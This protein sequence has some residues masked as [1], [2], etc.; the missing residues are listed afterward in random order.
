MH[1]TDLATELLLQICH[2]LPTIQSVLALSSTCRH[3]RTL[4]STHRLPILYLA[5]EAELGPLPDA[6]RLVTH[7]ATQPVHIIRPAP[8]HSLALLE[9]LLAVG[10]VANKLVTLYPSQKWHGG[11]K[12]CFRRSLTSLEERHLRRAVYRL[13]LYKFAFHNPT[14]TRRTRL[15]PP[16]VRSRAALL[17]PWPASE[18]AEVLDIHTLLRGLLQY[19]ICPS[20]GTVLRRHKARYPL[21]QTPLVY[22]A[23]VKYNSSLQQQL[24]FQAKFFHSTPQVS[25]LLVS[26]RE[27]SRGGCNGMVEGWGDEIAHYYVVEDMLKL[28]PGQ[29]IWLFEHVTGTGGGGLVS[30]SAKDTVQSFVAGIGGEWFENNGET[31]G[32]TVAFVVGERGGEMEELRE[33]VE[34][35]VEGIVRGA[36]A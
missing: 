15:Q 29:I 31:F 12:S 9:R 27:Y 4:I 34:D 13:W 6:I 14:H 1:L 7:N 22:N 17:R 10:R 28:D 25:K 36:F 35:G 24:E 33:S 21:E 2:S 8:P 23:Q 18:L 19:H 11:E 16:I 20:N 30:G 26:S 32:E 5:A 3:F